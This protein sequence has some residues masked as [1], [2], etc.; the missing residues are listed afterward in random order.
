[1]SKQEKLSKPRGDQDS[2]HSHP[3][4]S[5][6]G[7]EPG[8]HHHGQ[9]HKFDPANL[10]KLR[11]PERLQWQNP[12]ALWRAIGA[13]P[14]AVVV[15]VGAGIGFFSLPFARLAPQGWVYACDILPVMLEYLRKGMEHEKVPNITPVLCGEV[16]V[17]LPSGLADVVLMVNLHHEFHK[18]VDSLSEARRVLKSGGVLAAVDWKKMETPHGPPQGVR[19]ET[20]TVKKHLKASGFRDFT[21]H[22]ILPHHWF[23]TARV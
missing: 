4:A 15:D 2:A 21:E 14:D 11:D 12:E 1:M 17:P 22:D 19:V 9:G 20:D 3:E 23:L 13:K 10:E 18:P 16:K 5:K 8:H 7:A 6:H